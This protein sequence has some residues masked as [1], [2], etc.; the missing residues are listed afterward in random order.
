MKSYGSS[1]SRAG[2][3]LSLAALIAFGFL[4]Q[5]SW[6]EWQ[7]IGWIVIAGGGA[8][9]ITNPGGTERFETWLAALPALTFFAGYTIFYWRLPTWQMVDILSIGS[10][11]GYAVITLRRS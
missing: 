6:D 11:V 3:A 8:L 10:Y 5:L 4:S 7:P 2:V 1:L 9:A